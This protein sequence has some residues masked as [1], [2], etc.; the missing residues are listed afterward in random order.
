MIE[1]QKT[2]WTNRW[3]YSCILKVISYLIWH[4]SKLIEYRSDDVTKNFYCISVFWIPY[5]SREY[6]WKTF[7]AQILWKSVHGGP[8]IW[9]HEYLISPIEIGHISGPNEPIHVN[10]GVWGVF[11]M[12]YWNMAIKSAEMQK[13][14][15]VDVTVRYSVHMS[16]KNSKAV[17]LMFIF[18]LTDF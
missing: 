4:T 5:I 6:K 16:F 2:Q 11:I 10:V 18:T 15:F 14:K 17:M 7:T 9:P 13:R 12:F 1:T 3:A 8:E